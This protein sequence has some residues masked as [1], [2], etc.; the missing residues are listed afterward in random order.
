MID[1]RLE[2]LEADSQHTRASDHLSAVVLARGGRSWSEQAG[3]GQILPTVPY[4]MECANLW[5]VMSRARVSSVPVGDPIEQHFIA[6][7]E[8][9]ERRLREAL[10]AAFG[11]DVGREATAD[12]LGYAWQNWDRISSMDNPVGYLYVV[13]RNG[14]R[15]MLRSRRGI[16]LRY[17]AHT[18]GT[19]STFEPALAGLLVSLSERERAVVMLL[20]GFD[21]S[22]SEV[23]ATL[24]VS[25]STV[26]S[27]AER[28]LGKLRSGLGV[29]R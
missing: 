22:M 24:D 14:A 10:T 6:F 19:A 12:A 21:W 2:S 17:P 13:G 8:Q 16:Q 29:Q 23:A 5:R 26:Q 15:R 1:Q 4:G 11:V 3:D 20:Y 28:A 9:H 25:K 18:G 7:V 27:Y